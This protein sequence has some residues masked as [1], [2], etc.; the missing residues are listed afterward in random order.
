MSKIKAVQDKEQN[1]P[2]KIQVLECIT[3]IRNMHL[4]VRSFCKYNIILS[5]IFEGLYFREYRE[6]VR[7]HEIR[8][9]KDRIT[10]IHTYMH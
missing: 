8:Y 6:W 4:V 3:I 2:K 1:I 7:I 5:E 9:I 10:I